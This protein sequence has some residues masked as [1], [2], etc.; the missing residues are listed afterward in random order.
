MEQNKRHQR[1]D[2]NWVKLC[3]LW[4]VAATRQTDR[5]TDRQALDNT[6]RCCG[7]GCEWDELK[8]EWWMRRWIVV[9]VQDTGV[10]V[11]R[12]WCRELDVKSALLSFIC[13]LPT[14]NEL[15]DMFSCV[16]SNSCPW[17]RQHVKRTTLCEIICYKF[18]SFLEQPAACWMVHHNYWSRY[19]INIRREGV[20][21]LSTLST[22]Q[23]TVKDQTDQN[24][25]GWMVGYGLAAFSPSTATWYHG[26]MQRTWTTVKCKYRQTDRQTDRRTD[27]QSSICCGVCFQRTSHSII[28]A[29]HVQSSEYANHYNSMSVIHYTVPRC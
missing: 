13:F 21:S 28:T 15:N 11:H 2:K 25:S 10:T 23:T 6:E 19:N 18:T 9:N 3:L 29:L 22:M 1:C 27:G 4:E 14:N 17:R 20:V 12:Q 26:D 5:Q 7:Q 16:A 24:T 8:T